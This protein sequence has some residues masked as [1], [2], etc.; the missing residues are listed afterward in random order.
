MIPNVF[1]RIILPYGFERN[2]KGEW[3]AFNREYAPIGMID[4]RSE[5]LNGHLPNYLKYEGL[6]DS[7]IQHLVDDP[8]SI[9]R[10]TAGDIITFTLYNDRTNP[11][12][13]RMSEER[14]LLYSS[15]FNKL[16]ILSERNLEAMSPKL[17]K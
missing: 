15:Y 16:K 13:E 8:E 1:F 2:A 17:H 4:G 14:S 12:A 3:C 5:S 10:D 9:Q 6:S 7:F 11:T